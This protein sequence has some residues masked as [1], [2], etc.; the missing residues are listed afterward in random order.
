[1]GDPRPAG[2]HSAGY[3]EEQGYPSETVDYG[4]GVPGQGYPSD[5]AERGRGATGTGQGYAPESAQYGRTEGRTGAR[6]YPEEGYGQGAGAGRGEHMGGAAL[7]VL[8]GLLTAFVGITGIIRSIFFSRVANYPFYYSVR[9]RGI[10][11]I[12]IG[13]LLVGV[14]VCMVLGM[15]WARHL[16]M[17]VLVVA[18]I[19][20]FLFVPFYPFW[21]ILLLGLTVF[22]LWEV[23]RTRHAGRQWALQRLC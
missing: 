11:E 1:M 12:I 21:G 10:T 16:A 3:Q 19:T 23:A 15:H 20:A 4:S 9:S 13:A 7:T 6:G 22:T 5:T 17:L 2:A 8:T 18:A 14:G